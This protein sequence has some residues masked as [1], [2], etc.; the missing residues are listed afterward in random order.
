[1]AY[2]DMDDFLKRYY[3]QLHISEM[4]T[5]VMARLVDYKKDGILTE[6]QQDWFDNYLE[7]DPESSLGYK[8]KD[9][10]SPT[11]TEQ[12][13]P[14]Q[15]EKLYKAFSLAMAGMK[16]N[17]VFWDKFDD[18]ELNIF[19]KEWYDEKKLF[20]IPSATDETEEAIVALMDV[21]TN[22]PEKENIKQII[23]DNAK[24]P[25][26]PDEA[27]FSS[28][29]E[30]NTFLKDKVIAKKYNSDI[31]VQPKLKTIAYVLY[32][33]VSALTFAD[34]NGG[35][36]ATKRAL[37]PISSDLQILF[38]D[39]AFSNI[40][41]D[42]DIMEKF[43]NGGY[44]DALLRTLYTNKT[45]RDKFEQFD[46]K[47]IVEKITKFGEGK[48]KW[49]DKESVDYVKPK[50][51]DQLNPVQWLEKQAKDTYSNT[52][53]K[54]EELRGAHLFQSPQA[55]DIFKAIDKEKIKPSDGLEGLLGKVQAVKDRINNKK[56]AE[57]FDW[58]VETIKEIQ[59]DAPKAVAGAWKDASQMK[60]II[61]RIILKTV[62]QSG[63]KRDQGSVLADMEKAKTAMELMTVMKYGTL[64]SN[65][66]NAINNS[67]F[68]L[69]SDGSLSWN[70]NEAIKFITSAFDQ[71]IK[72]TLKGFGYGISAVRNKFMLR[73]LEYTKDDNDKGKTGRLSAAYEKEQKRLN[74]KYGTSNPAERKE[75]LRTEIERM[76]DIDLANKR[77]EQEAIGD[78][79]IT[80]R[81]GGRIVKVSALGEEKERIDSLLEAHKKTMT[82]QSALRDKARQ[83]QNRYKE[84][85]DELEESVQAY[86]EAKY[87]ASGQEEKDILEEISNIDTEIKKLEEKIKDLNKT[88]NASGLLGA[89]GKPLVSQAEKDAAKM[90]IEEHK[91]ELTE[92]ANQKAEVQ[93]KLDEIKSD[94]DRIKKAKT[95]LKELKPAYDKRK[96][97]SKSYDDATKMYKTADRAY[98]A[99]ERQYNDIK[100]K[101]GYKEI[102]EKVSEFNAATEAVKE[103]ETNIEDKEKKLASWD[104]DHVNRVAYLESYW[105]YLQTGQLTTY[106]WNTKN[107]Q[108][109]FDSVDEATGQIRKQ[110]MLADYM[111]QHGL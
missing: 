35:G 103:L 98:T 95:Q 10:P 107:A 29:E 23:L 78:R 9:V 102:E 60:L 108:K 28:I 32:E 20:E 54:Y 2:T 73:K 11:D 92:L 62:G 51:E 56:V 76:R 25:D 68:S 16:G 77:A 18:E 110:K 44:A 63:D 1:M 40:K 75:E 82:D 87:I 50:I 90:Q 3:K 111:S 38:R 48:A 8:S 96:L 36:T 83:A 57:H 74:S 67:E 72:L 69:F 71:G 39:D 22:S 104:E 65:L 7:A 97:L 37:A 106:R 15:L 45:V 100:V 53:K 42:A 31:K 27:M 99:A 12:L 85:M 88:A 59:N 41:V 55:R 49:H 17:S 47:K 30:I 80:L 34:M 109:D 26:K 86:N 66:V 5:D 4:P 46:K 21:L 89:N 79:E 105:N 91:Q 93:Q 24:K 94:P 101:N 81:N 6:H 43:G 33:N 84:Q 64:T 70:K 52:L 14:D 19:L 58:F 13:A 61:D